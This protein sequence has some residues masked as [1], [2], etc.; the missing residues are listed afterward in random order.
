ML[1]VPQGTPLLFRSTGA[2]GS[3]H[4]SSGGAARLGYQESRSRPAGRLSTLSGVMHGGGLQ[5]LSVLAPE[6]GA[7]ERSEDAIVIACGAFG[8][9]EHETTASC[10][11]VL[12]RLELDGV[13]LL[14]LGSGTGI[15]AVAALALGAEHAVCVDPDPSAFDTAHRN[16]E[17]N[18]MSK[19][20]E[21]V[22]GTLVEVTQPT[23][24]MVVA[25]LYGDVLLAEAD[26][27]VSRVA[28]G[29]RLLLSGILWQDQFAVEQRYQALGC[30]LD[31]TWMLEEYCTLLLTRRSETNVAVELACPQK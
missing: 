7:D 26:L 14:D 3:W 9:G 29:G 11:E 2:S 6:T 1:N 28:E 5:R 22:L 24:D 23:F 15:L 19:R 13:R 31:R 12:E 27:L 20:I 16:A 17:L 8:S 4:I 21:H 30:R 10:L 18:G 25:N